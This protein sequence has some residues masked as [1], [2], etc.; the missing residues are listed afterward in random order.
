MLNLT[1]SIDLYFDML[2]AHGIDLPLAEHSML[3]Y[4]ISQ[5]GDLYY[6]VF[7]K[8]S[9]DLDQSVQRVNISSSIQKHGKSLLTLAELIGLDETSSLLPKAIKILQEH[10]QIPVEYSLGKPVAKGLG[11]LATANSSGA[12]T[13]DFP[14]DLIEDTFDQP[15]FLPRAS[16]VAIIDQGERG[17]CVAQ[18]VAYAL[19]FTTGKTFSSMKMYADFKCLDGVPQQ[20]GTYATSIPKLLTAIGQPKHEASWSFEL[21]DYGVVE[22]DAWPYNP[23]K[24]PGN[25]H[26]LPPKP[27]YEAKLYEQT[28]RY[29]IKNPDTLL[30]LDVKNPE[31]LVHQIRSCILNG[32]P[33]VGGFKMFSNN[34]NKW[35][36]DTGR[37]LIPPSSASVVGY[38][39]QA[40]AGFDDKEQRFYG[41]Q[42]WGLS[43][44]SKNTFKPGF[45]S[46]PY[47]YIQN[48]ASDFFVF[49]NL[50]KD[51]GLTIPPKY[52]LSA[53]VLTAQVSEGKSPSFFNK[54]I[55]S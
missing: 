6:A 11:L 16:S 18:S 46:Y 4:G 1:D 52:R 29:R 28:N 3:N 34:Q 23:K 32:Y 13:T 45:F 21:A 31:I 40:I 47:R 48:Y 9:A 33:V 30:R 19:Y 8:A 53:K 12:L 17:T 39:E 50:D 51:E 27:K 14:F 44:G 22:A 10:T 49:L 42:S 43:F 2:Q 54:L 7:T 5:V 20:S 41:P 25:E 24:I 36:Y 37:Y 15:Q 38:H 35:A 26:Q 55:F